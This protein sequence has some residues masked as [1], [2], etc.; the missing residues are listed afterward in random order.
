MPSTPPLAAAIARY[1]DPLVRYAMRIVGDRE[2]ARDVVQDT[3]VRLCEAG[4]DVDHER[5]GAW[6]YAVCRN[7]AVDVR[8]REARLVPL[9]VEP[10]AVEGSDPPGD[11]WEMLGALDEVKRRVITLRYEAGHS[12][13]SISALTGLSVSNVGF[14]LHA[15]VRALRKQLAAAALLVFVVALIVWPSGEEQLAP[16]AAERFE[17]PVLVAPPPSEKVK[18]QKIAAE[19]KAAPAPQASQTPIPARP[20]RPPAARRPVDMADAW[21]AE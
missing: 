14:V 3:F 8:R 11:V 13:K 1:H 19:P 15:T 18:R 12:Y 10:E 7:R 21:S 17:V 20:A 16:I 9:E 6:L 4:D 5:M 2:R